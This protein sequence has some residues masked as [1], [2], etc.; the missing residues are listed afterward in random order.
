MQRTSNLNE[1]RDLIDRG[2]GINTG[3][4]GATGRP[5]APHVY[6]QGGRVMARK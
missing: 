4:N 3:G 6:G 5:G 1:L 2:A